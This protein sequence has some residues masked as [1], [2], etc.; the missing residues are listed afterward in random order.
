MAS[1]PASY[2]P[3][4]YGDL[5]TRYPPGPN[6]EG[7]DLPA[8]ETAAKTLVPMGYIASSS[9]F[10]SN[11]SHVTTYLC[12]PR[13]V[14]NVVVTSP[15]YVPGTDRRT[16]YVTL[17]NAITTA[18]TRVLRQLLVQL[19]VRPADP[20]TSSRATSVI[21]AWAGRS[22]YTSPMGAAL[23]SWGDD[24]EFFNCVAAVAVAL[25]SLAPRVAMARSGS[26]RAWVVNLLGILESGRLPIRKNNIAVTA[27]LARTLCRIYLG[28]DTRPLDAVAAEVAAFAAQNVT[29]DGFI[30][31]ESRQSMTVEYQYRC[32]TMILLCQCV[33]RQ[34]GGVALTMSRV[35]QSALGNVVANLDAVAARGTPTVSSPSFFH[36]KTGCTEAMSNVTADQVTQLRQMMDFAFGSND[37]AKLTK[38]SYLWASFTFG[39]LQQLIRAIAAS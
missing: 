1:Q 36:D 27:M 28:R 4:L 3:S 33:L 8:L 19:S 6:W 18:P 29:P 38:T 10:V 39:D 37:P 23:P 14:T 7:V 32:A 30:T 11:L 16:R 12:D 31:T 22:L 25:I 9:A 5:V 34:A 17:M 26:V 15:T 21:G 2:F 24:L 13:C 20:A 35:S